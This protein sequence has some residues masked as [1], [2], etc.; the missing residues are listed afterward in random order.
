MILDYLCTYVAGEACAGSD[1]EAVAWVAPEELP[2]YDLPDKAL[3]VVKDAFARVGSAG[4]LP[5]AP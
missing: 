2:A 1:A 3:E 5:P 4:H